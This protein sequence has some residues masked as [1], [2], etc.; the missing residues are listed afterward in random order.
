MSFSIKKKKKDKD[1]ELKEEEAKKEAAEY[2]HWKGLISVDE[3]GTGANLELEK[4]GLS[5]DFVNYIK[6]C[7]YVWGP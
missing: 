2:N 7:M 1:K 4:Q 5:E 3:E 6:V